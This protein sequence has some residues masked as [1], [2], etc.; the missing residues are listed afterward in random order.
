M[1]DREEAAWV[2]FLRAQRHVLEKL[3]AELRAEHSLS[4]SEFEV[5]LHLNNAPRNAL[6][7]KELAANVLVTPSGL[8]RLADRMVKQGLIA[9]ETCPSDRRGYFLVLTA[10][11]RERYEAASPTHFRGV[12]DHFVRFLG[13]D[14]SVVA[15]ALGRIAA[16]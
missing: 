11:G 16:S 2:G 7:M 15:E 13:D 10:S 3:E 12:S 4:L 14:A 8:T 9:R 5:L 1:N 6:R